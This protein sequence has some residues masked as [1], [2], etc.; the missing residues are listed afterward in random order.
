MSRQKESQ[1][2]NTY[3][4]V[5]Y[6]T[7]NVMWYVE[8]G[9]LI[10]E[11]PVVSIH[12]YRFLVVGQLCHLKCRMGLF[13][14]DFTVMSKNFTPPS[15]VSRTAYLRPVWR[16]FAALY[17]RFPFLY[18]SVHGRKE[19]PKLRHCNSGAGALAL[20]WALEL[21]WFNCFSLMISE[22]YYTLYV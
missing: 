13:L 16:P 2:P 7:Q 5:L 18:M 22:V 11:N 9:G 4:C 17:L 10:W 1:S 8:Y 21:E 20:T 12:V 15:P 6:L 19:G 3:P 14:V